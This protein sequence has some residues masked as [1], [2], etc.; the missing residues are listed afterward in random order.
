M[1]RF[2]DISTLDDN[3]EQF[4]RPDGGDGRDLYGTLKQSPTEHPKES[5]K[6]NS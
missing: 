2:G 5:S 4:L 1:D 3:I 6:G